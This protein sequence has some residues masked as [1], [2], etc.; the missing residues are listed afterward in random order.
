MS[1]W[2]GRR[3]W[4]SKLKLSAMP[5]KWREFALHKSISSAATEPGKRPPSQAQGSSNAAAYSPVW[6]GSHQPGQVQGQV[7]PGL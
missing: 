3:K 4:D 1:M 7:S 2:N 5:R 6:R